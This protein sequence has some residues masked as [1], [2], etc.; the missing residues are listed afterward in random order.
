M[1]FLPMYIRLSEYASEGLRMS[2][3]MKILFICTGNSC[4]SQ[5][6]EGWV[7][8][9]KA[10]TIQAYSAGVE[11]HGLNARAVK[12]MAEAGAD[13]TGQHSKHVNA[14]AGSYCQKLWMTPNLKRRFSC[15]L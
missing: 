7:N 2:N 14:L 6:A 12:V 4:R 5:M 1:I 9:L 3:K 11:P 15:H 10:D 8:A 13:I